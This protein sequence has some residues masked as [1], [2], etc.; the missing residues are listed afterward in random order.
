MVLSDYLYMQRC[1][2]AF[3]ITS[4][5]IYNL[6][7]NDKFKPLTWERIR[8]LELK[9]VI[10]ILMAIALPIEII[11]DI[12]MV[13]IIYQEGFMI[14]PLDGKTIITKQPAFWSPADKSLIEFTLY[15]ADITTAFQ[16]SILFLLQCFWNYLS[17][18]ITKKTFMGSVEWM[19]YLIWAF[20]TLIMHPVL[21]RIFMY[22][23]VLEE[24]V[25]LFA[26]CIECLIV[27]ALG[28]VS[29]TR[30][31]RLI[32]SHM[33]SQCH[34]S[35]NV[36]VSKLMYFREMNAALSVFLLIGT[37]TG[38]AVSIDA[39]TGGKAILYSKGFTDALNCFGVFGEVIAWI[40]L[41]SIFF[42]S[43][44]YAV[45]TT[46]RDA[47]SDVQLSA[48]KK[49]AF[50]LTQDS[51]DPKNTTNPLTHVPS[52]TILRSVKIEIDDGPQDDVT[53]LHNRGY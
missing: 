3:Y 5:F 17:N 4:Y 18:A 27:S 13:R 16:V 15:A 31:N 33:T 34:L 1:A 43:R 35:N 41:I 2:G 40:L 19:A 44:V 36:V 7:R 30:F 6:W 38:L 39:I 47:T 28:L 8:R 29:H 52:T 53:P 32:S 14:S 11:Y 10:C 45:E 12:S 37:T 42:P 20:A 21:H 24:L 50:S 9:S 48:V 25:P 26:F 22:D 49:S 51:Q 23:P 46:S